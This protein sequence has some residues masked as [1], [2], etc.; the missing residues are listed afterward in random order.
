MKMQTVVNAYFSS[1]LILSFIPVAV[2]AFSVATTAVAV[3]PG[4]AVVNET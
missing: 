4:D 2:V 1:E 3:D